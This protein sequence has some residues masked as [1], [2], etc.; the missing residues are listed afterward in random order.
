MILDKSISKEEE[1]IQPKPV[2]H[3]NQALK[4]TPEDFK[5]KILYDKPIF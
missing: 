2:L 4:E 1:R 5:V 3:S